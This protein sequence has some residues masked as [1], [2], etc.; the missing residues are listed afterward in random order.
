[1]VTASRGAGSGTLQG[2]TSRTAANG[3]VTFTNL[4]HI[5]ATNI[6]LVFS[7][8][9]LVSTTSTAVAISAASASQLAFTTQPGNAVAGSV[10]GAQPVIQTQDQFGNNSTSSL[11][12]SLNVSVAL[13]SASGT[14]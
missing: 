2:T 8:S 11:P 7:G 13:S 3:I 5:V 12:A 9:G 4:S 14:L 10:F 1:L 6:T